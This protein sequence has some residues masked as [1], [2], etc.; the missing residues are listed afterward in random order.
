M[1]TTHR[2]AAQAKR[3]VR[4]EA[5]ASAPLMLLQAAGEMPAERAAKLSA[6]ARACW[7]RLRTG[8]GNFDDW[9][10]LAQVVNICMVRSEAIDP[11]L[12]Q[13]C[14]SAMD[15]LSTLRTRA[16]QPQG[17]WGPDHT[18]LEHIPQLL[19][20]NDELLKN[21][22]PLQISNARDEAVRRTKIKHDLIG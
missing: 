10:H 8:H 15:S 13:E 2:R 18:S 5:D 7:E 19:D 9:R 3:R 21:S 20:L 17:R 16:L 14:Q 22:S 1:K 4:W 12:V 6:N 11:L